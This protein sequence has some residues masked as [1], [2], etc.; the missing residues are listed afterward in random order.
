[1]SY[2]LL[3]YCQ[4]TCLSLAL[5]VAGC[6]S[7]EGGTLGPKTGAGAAIGAAGGGL[8]AAAAG[9]KSKGIIAGVLIGGLLG[10]AIG[11]SLDQKDRKL[12]REAASLSLENQPSGTTTNWHNPDSGNSGGFTPT[13]TYQKA[14]GAYCREY[15]QTVTVGGEK[16]KAYGTACRQPDGTWKIV[17]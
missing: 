11:N 3:R 9:G 7:Q 16:Q 2:G 14:D 12:A 6:A 4:I 13:S 15:E 10:G 8:L 5:V 17:S 1:M